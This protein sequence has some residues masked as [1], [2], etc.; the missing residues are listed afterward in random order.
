[1][2]EWFELKHRNTSSITRLTR[3][4]V[5]MKRQCEIRQHEDTMW[6]SSTW[7]HNVRFVNM[8]AQCE[9]R[10][11]EE[12]MWD[13]STWR[14]NVRFVNMKTQFEIRQHEDTMWDSSTWR[15]NVR[16]VNMKRLWDSFVSSRHVARMKKMR[17]AYE[18]AGTSRRLLWTR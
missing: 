7:R 13:S 14:D 8:K 18:V 9:I 2:F 1:M 16:F 10:Q 15:D 17:N 12:T 11:H 5:N 4:F 3:G 6:D